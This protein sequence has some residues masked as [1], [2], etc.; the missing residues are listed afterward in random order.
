MKN[1]PDRTGIARLDRGIALRRQMYEVAKVCKNTTITFAS[2]GRYSR[3]FYVGKLYARRGKGSRAYATYG[4]DDF[5]A[6]WIEHG[7]YHLR[8]YAPLRRAAQ[9][10][11]LRLKGERP[12]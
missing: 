3:G 10:L 7:N 1:K 11:G 6:L 4:S 9:V 8:R 5:K 12:L 2:F